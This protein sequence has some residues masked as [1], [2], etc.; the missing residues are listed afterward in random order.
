MSKAAPKNMAASIQAKL[1]HKAGEFK[2]DPNIL[3]MR[4]A[5]E[6]FL[7]RLGLSPYSRRLTLKGAMLFSLWSD[8]LF[9]PTKD[10]DFLLTGESSLAAVEKMI[11]EICM[12]PVPED[13]GMGF[14]PAGVV[15][16]RIKE[17]QVYGGVRV[18]LTACLGKIPVP[19][20]LE[21]EPGMSSP[22]NPSRCRFR[23]SSARCRRRGCLSI[24]ARAW[25]QRSWRRWSSWIWP[26]AG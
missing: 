24:R 7:Y 4:Y 15:V 1:N 8:E 23:S 12:V 17:D 13:D 14:D 6:R 20:Q 25:W 11:R 19:I 9:R 10:A 5:L 2:L 3:R 26:T 22:R 18:S 16:E 21:L